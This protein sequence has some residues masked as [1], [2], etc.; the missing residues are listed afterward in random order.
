MTDLPTQP[1]AEEQ[2][3]STNQ[4]TSPGGVLQYPRTIPLDLSVKN[5]QRLTSGMINFVYRLHLNEA[6]GE[7]QKQKTAILKYSAPFVAG[8]AHV[9]V[10][11][12]RHIFEARALKEILWKLFHYPPS[13][14]PGD[15]RVLSV[16]L[17]SVYFEDETNRITIMQDCR[18][19]AVE[20]PEKEENPFRFFCE[21]ASTFETKSHT[22]RA[23]GSALGSFLAQ[24]HAWG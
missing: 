23:V 18:L 2:Q 20:H 22:A 10:S 9:S 7:E 5:A 24:V 15:S 1:T 8:K 14:V 13:V 4:L 17:P 3:Y 11:P 6:I 19:G 12:H 16:S 21:R